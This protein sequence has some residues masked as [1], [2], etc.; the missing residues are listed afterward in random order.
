MQIIIESPLLSN[1]TLPAHPLIYLY[2]A[3]SSSYLPM[4]G[5]LIITALAGKLIPVL[6]VQVAHNINISPSLNP[7][8][9]ISLSSVVNPEWW[10]P[11]P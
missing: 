11:I 9:I 5:P 3:L 8:S 10:Y 6:R 1:P 2:L 4:N 7:L